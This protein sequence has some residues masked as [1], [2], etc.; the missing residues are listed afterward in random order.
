MVLSA[1]MAH[2]F[3]RRSI[4]AGQR[5]AQWDLIEQSDL[6]DQSDLMVRPF[7]RRRIM[8]PQAR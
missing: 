3:I 2:P 5:M 1:L 4:W 8:A 7:I 6:M